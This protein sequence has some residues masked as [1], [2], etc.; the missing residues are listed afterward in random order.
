[1]EFVDSVFDEKIKHKPD[2]IADQLREKILQHSKEF[3]T[4][5]VN[6]G[7][8]LYT[9]WKDKFFIGWGYEKFEHYLEKEV[10]LK[11]TVALKLLKTYFFLEQDEP[12][13][14]KKEFVETRDPVQVPHYEA[15]NI[16]R[17][18]RQKKELTRDDY[19]KL[20]NAIFEKGKDASLVRR[21]LVSM[22]R[23]RKP[24][25]PEEEREQRN[26]AAIRRLL[27]SLKSFKKDMETLKLAP[28]EFI[29]DAEEFISKLESHVE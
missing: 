18:A 1:M 7:Q 27:N 15:V 22:M 19:A 4:S 20:K 9:V 8:A 2:M 29:Q 11:K 21:D 26:L 5:W 13:Y 16:L 3:K 12:S 10:S 25:D 24:V 17:L 6:L 14:L 28:S 23:E